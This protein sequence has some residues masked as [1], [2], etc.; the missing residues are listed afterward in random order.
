MNASRLAGL[1]VGLVCGIRVAAIPLALPVWLL[2]LLLLGGLALTLAGVH[3]ER[4]WQPWP[5][6]LVLVAAVLLGFAPGYRRMTGVTGDP[7]PGSLRAHLLSVEDGAPLH[8]RGT[9]SRE[10]ERR[11]ATQ[12][13]L[14]I[15][16][17]ALRVGPEPG[18]PWHPV[19]GGEARIRVFVYPGNAAGTHAHFDRL[20]MPQAYG[21]TV[22][23]TAPFQTESGRLNP[24]DFDAARFLREGGAD[25]R[26]RCHAGRVSILETSRGNLLMELALAA[27][28]DFLE[29]I[30][31]TIR[32][33]ASRL[34]AAAT[35]GARRAVEKSGYRGTDIDQMF[36]HAGV[37]HVLAVSGLHVSVIA[38]ML[39]ALFRLTGL[40][41]RLFVPPLIFFLILF[42]LLTGARPSSVRAVVMNS[43]ILMA[44]AYFRCD[45]RQ[46]TT[47]GLSI[48]AL[49]IL[50][51]SPRV[52]FSPG[53]L[54]SY[55]AV[56]S[57]IALVPATDRFLRSLRGYSLFG[58]GLWFLMILW[59][60][61]AAMHRLCNPLNVLALAG[62]LW[63]VLAGGTVL[64]HRH[65][66][67]WTIGLERMPAVARLFIAAQLSI[68]IGMMI[69]LSAWFFGQFPVAGILVNL[70]AIPAIAVLVQLGM[71]TGLI[72]LLPVAGPWLALPI[73]AAATLVGH[74]FILLAYG[75]MLAF[76]FPAVP[77]PSLSWMMAYY[78]VVA[79]F[80]WLTRCRVRILEMVGRGV[81]V[82]RTRL[83]RGYVWFSL[84]LPLLLL[85][86][87]LLQAFF[88]AA[89]ASRIDVLAAGR[90]P[91]VV[92]SGGGQAVVINA[93][94]RFEGERLVFN[95]VRA[96]G[97]T[98][99]AQL[100]LPSPEPRAGVEGATAL[101]GKM[102]VQSVYLPLLPK[103]D[104]QLTDAIGDRY[105]ME[106]AA[107]GT[108]WAI[109]YDRAF[110]E[111][112]QRT[113]RYGVPLAGIGTGVPTPF[114]GVDL[115]V[116]PRLQV[117][118]PRFAASAMAPVLGMQVH[119]LA[120]VIVTDT[121]PEALTV[122]LAGV[123]HCDV[124][125]VPNLDAY[126]TYTAWL[127]KAVDL[128]RPRLVIIGGDAPVDAGKLRAVL[129]DKADLVVFQTGVD[130]AASAVPLPG[131]GAQ[132]TT[133]RTRQQVCLKPPAAG[134][135]PVVSPRRHAG[136]E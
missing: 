61:G 105:L 86:L 38:V 91:L 64:N 70:V 85:S 13:D 69:P 126:A 59:I 15:R 71:M 36:R 11:A 115:R 132:L 10:P 102:Q 119:G 56:L 35:L 24:S 9:V 113:G 76:P 100:V 51:A 40:S 109:R 44:I 33:P 19:T 73:G 116:L 54:L 128:L 2:A 18:S 31:R 72:G 95:S 118:P 30:K 62:V 117:P 46:A 25:I 83:G 5:P 90:Y 120:W 93:G 23:V 101:L 63:L 97:A 104:Q 133:Y 110:E 78:A 53:F 98:R 94:G 50:L 7:L 17:T 135:P 8:L 130:G 108:A 68:Q 80:L 3:A 66:V 49:V 136:T 134:V 75:G 42:A 27:K 88:P 28:A 32:S 55:G 129:R 106:Q 131:G 67:M 16:V 79:M 99:I 29:T 22:E 41:P 57:L 48:S 96:R 125:V 84:L 1:A 37:G 60:A 52:L 26:L 34:T 121:T 45:L 112:R 122:A 6:G 107:A 123:D 111:F 82:L 4:R 47:M 114:P 12:L 14:Q 124:L 58:F 65:P 89:P 21:Y 77:L 43:A 81:P 20:S 39:F 127:R 103:A 87:P 92:I 74:F